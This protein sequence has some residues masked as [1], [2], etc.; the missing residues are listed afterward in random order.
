MMERKN[1]RQ[2]SCKLYSE[3]VVVEDREARGNLVNNLKLGNEREV[4]SET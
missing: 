1:S 2:N 4:F 3:S